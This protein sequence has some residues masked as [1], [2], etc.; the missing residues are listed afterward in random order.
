M[1]YHFPKGG[2]KILK[3]GRPPPKKDPAH[4]Y[5]HVLSIMQCRSLKLY[6]DYVE[7]YQKSVECLSRNKTENPLF[8]KFLEVRSNS[9]SRPS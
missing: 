6:K 7:M 9:C 8:K 2:H 1:L 5:T 3:G 4:V